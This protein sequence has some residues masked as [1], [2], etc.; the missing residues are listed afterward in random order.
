MSQ[1][2]VVVVGVTDADTSQAICRHLA[3]TGEVVL[4]S[5]RHFDDILLAVLA[6]N[7]DLLVLDLELEGVNGFKSVEV[8]R[9]ACPSLQLIVISPD[10]AIEKGR[11]IL[12][13]GIFYYA[14]KPVPTPELLAALDQAVGGRA[15]GSAKHA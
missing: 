11:K 15:N 3:K 14:I 10:P 2:H 12:A 1:A 4:R 9:R 5:M 13:H 8:L 6:G 7:A